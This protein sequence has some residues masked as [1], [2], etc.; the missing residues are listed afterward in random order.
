MYNAIVYLNG[1]HVINGEYTNNFDLKF[2]YFEEV[3][4]ILYSYKIDPSNITIIDF[5]L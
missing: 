3:D 4:E 5:R 1:Y 2:N